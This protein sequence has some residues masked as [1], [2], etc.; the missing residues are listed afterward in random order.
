M[1]RVLYSDL[2]LPLCQVSVAKFDYCGGF[3]QDGISSI[4][5]GF[6]SLFPGSK[7]SLPAMSHAILGGKAFVYPVEITSHFLEKD[8]H[9]FKSGFYSVITI[10]YFFQVKNLIFTGLFF[11]FFM[12]I[13]GTNNKENRQSRDNKNRRCF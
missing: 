4:M 10:F 6:L 8:T 12:Y 5:G 13:I 11:P 7:I 9:M 1:V 2:T 3:G